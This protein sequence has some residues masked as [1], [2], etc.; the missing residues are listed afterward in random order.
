ME[1]FCLEVIFRDGTKYTIYGSEE[2]MKKSYDEFKEFLGM[3]FKK[4]I[5]IVGFINTLEQKNCLVV[6]VI[7]HIASVTY[8]KY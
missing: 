8:F 4:T 7:D 6:L 3:D 1:P 2:Q 5:E